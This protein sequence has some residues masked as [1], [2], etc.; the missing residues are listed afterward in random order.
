MNSEILKARTKRFAIICLK[1]CKRIPPSL[2]NNVL[3]IQLSKAGT[4]VGANYRAACRARSQNEFIAKLQ[5][6]TEE[7]DESCYWLEVIREA[8]VLEDSET[9][10][11]LKEAKELNAIFTASLNTAKKNRWNKK[12]DEK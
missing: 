4:S 9:L 11:L 10:N 2:E 7:A 1:T 3:K 5:I 8:E 6:V 12:N